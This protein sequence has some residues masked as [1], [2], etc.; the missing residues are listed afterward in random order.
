[1]RA[2]MVAIPWLM[3]CTSADDSA[4]PYCEQECGDYYTV[5]AL[6]SI[7]TKVWASALQDTAPNKDGVA[8]YEAVPVPCIEGSLAVS[9]TAT[10]KSNGGIELDLSVVHAGCKQSDPKAAN[11]Y[12]TTTTGT[13][14]WDGTFVDGGVRNL[15]YQSTELEFVGTVNEQGV[16]WSVEETCT[17][18]VT[19]TSKSTEE[20]SFAGAWCGRKLLDPDA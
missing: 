20:F 4:A 14:D 9:G 15:R 6:D 5:R 17:L 8:T 3:A 10:S 7:H 13:I 2:T 12:T 19:L 18:Q 16:A 11:G 1:M